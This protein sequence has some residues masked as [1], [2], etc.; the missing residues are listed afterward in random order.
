MRRRAVVNAILVQAVRRASQG[1][2]R[3]GRG[4]SDQVSRQV[5]K[6]ADYPGRGKQSYYGYK[7]HVGMDEDSGHIRRAGFAPAGVHDS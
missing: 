1:N 7:M 3:D 4:S 5:D 2:S 6:N